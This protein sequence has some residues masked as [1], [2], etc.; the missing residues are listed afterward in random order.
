MSKSV[1]IT[2]GAGF[3]GSSIAISLK[4]KYPSYDVICMDNLHRR[5]SELNLPRLR[6]A[7]ISFVHG[8]IRNEEDFDPVGEVDILIDAAAEPSVLAGMDGSIDYLLKTNFNGTINALKF[9]Q[10]HDAIFMF[11]STSRI[12]PI[13]T[14]AKAQYDVL[15]TRFAF[16]NN[17]EINGISKLGISESLN[18][19]G[20][21]SLYG[22]SKLASEL[23]VEEFKQF[24]N[25]KTIINRCGVLS[26]EYQMG[27]VDQGVVVLWMARH[28]WKKKL[29][30]IGFG[31]TGKQTRDVLHVDDLFNLIDYQ[32]HHIDEVNGQIFNVGGGVETSFSLFELTKVCSEITG[33]EI[34]ITAVDDD[35]VGDIPIY[36]TDNTKVGNA[37][38]W[39][40]EVG[41]KEIM[42]R[43]YEWL[44]KDED[45][46]KAI[47][48]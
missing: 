39:K 15:D 2:G 13:E 28:F 34:D 37:S 23:F 3:V 22:S 40:P 21:R 38:G 46:L 25:L 43:I 8:D 20:A 10:K 42:E 32:L 47:L 48:S 17:P 18:L 4:K 5:G 31:G 29:S 27:K 16:G 11:L 1:L 24:F 7:E 26:G 30:Y 45:K 19:Q 44:R 9:A 35:R 6:A 12:Y 41:M 33:N 36:I 14:I